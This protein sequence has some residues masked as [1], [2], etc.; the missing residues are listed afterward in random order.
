MQK[1]LEAFRHAHI[2][3]LIYKT[4]TNSAKD[5]DDLFI[6]FDQ[7]RDRRKQELTNKKYNKGKYHIGIYLKG[8]FGCADHQ[9][10]GKS[11]TWSRI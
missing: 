11:Y 7:D 6:G 10:K 2:V 8:I 5:T 3:S 1:Y 9:E 4:T